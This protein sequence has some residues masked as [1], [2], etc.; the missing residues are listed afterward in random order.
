MAFAIARSIV[1][2]YNSKCG[3]VVWHR[4]ERAAVQHGLLHLSPPSCSE[5]SLSRTGMLYLVHTV[6]M[7]LRVF[8]WLCFCACLPFDPPGVN[9]RYRAGCLQGIFYSRPRMY[10]P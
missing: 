10:F 2:N 3:T 5:Y 6:C 1:L 8:N 9:D 7:A 4:N